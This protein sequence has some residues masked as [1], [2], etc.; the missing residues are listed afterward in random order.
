MT[1]QRPSVAGPL[2]DLWAAV[3]E[4]SEGERAVALRFALRNRDLFARSAD[5]HPPAPRMAA[6][7]AALTVLFAEASTR[8]TAVHQAMA[9]AVNPVVIVEAG[10][11]DSDQ[12]GNADEVRPFDVD[13]LRSL[14]G[15]ADGLD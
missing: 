9:D 10:R 14:W 5:D 8:A 7:F 15:I 4:L 12:S 3:V 1:D 2:E 13:V 11:D 6:L